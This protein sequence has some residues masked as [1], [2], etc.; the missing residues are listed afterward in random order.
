MGK[1]QCSRLAGRESTMMVCMFKGNKHRNEAQH[2]KALLHFCA[3]SFA[4][5]TYGE[6]A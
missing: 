1:V 3:G 6:L 4:C 2:Q 5:C